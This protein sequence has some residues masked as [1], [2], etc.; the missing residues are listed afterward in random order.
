MM[1]SS[2]PAQ[3][4]PRIEIQTGAGRNTLLRSSRPEVFLAEPGGFVGEELAPVSAK[5][6]D[7][8]FVFEHN[9]QT[10]SVA[11]LSDGVKFEDENHQPLP[12][13]KTVWNQNYLLW[14]RLD[15]A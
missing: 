6:K 7:K 15:R 14:H 12:D 2:S 11:G 13:K 8:V 9:E 1:P 4:A 5:L 3:Y 10:Y